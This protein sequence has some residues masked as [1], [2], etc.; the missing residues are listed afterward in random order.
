MKRATP[1]ELRPYSLKELAG[2]YKVSKNTFKKWLENFSD[3][4]GKRNGYYYSVLQVK[5]IFEKLGLPD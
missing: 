4:L 2:I 1:L 3:E 5:L